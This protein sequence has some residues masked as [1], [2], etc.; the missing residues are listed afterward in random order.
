M[1]SMTTIDAVP[2]YRSEPEGVPRGA[3]V[4]IHE[5]W[6][7]V[8]H[9]KAVADRY[10]REGYLVLAPDLLSE[11]GITPE[12]GEGLSGIY[13]EPDEAKRTAM[14]PQLREALAPAR[15]PEFGDK[16]VAAL[17]AVVDHLV[18]EPGI[19]DRIAVTGFCFGGTYS[20]ALAANDERV[21]AAIAFYGTA[22]S[23]EKIADIRC[24][25]LALYGE[26]DPP[27]VERLPAV[28]AQMADAG[29][30]FIDHVYPG[31]LHA[32]FND[33]NQR[34]YDPEA[35]ADAWRRT[36]AFLDARL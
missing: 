25:I 34:T 36:L 6:G 22:P 35:A 16:A 33:T 2:V 7:L 21:R 13:A 8:D 27:I 32:F 29:V 20:F 28:R 23:S 12:V 14:Q 19:D 30:D 9:I 11:V 5:I 4:L 18:T 17:K 10:S 26:N 24:P 31:A 3:I 15:A 1:G